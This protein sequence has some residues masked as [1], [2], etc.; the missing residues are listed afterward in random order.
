MHPAHVLPTSGPPG[1]ELKE[2][3]GPLVM[4]PSVIR[5]IVRPRL[6][7]YKSIVTC[8]RSVGSNFCAF[9]RL[10]PGPQ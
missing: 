8:I 7:V 6:L 3:R 10:R 9:Y 1:Q 4:L 5:Q 2:L